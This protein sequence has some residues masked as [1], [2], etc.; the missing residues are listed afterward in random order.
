M[1]VFRQ[2]ANLR[3]LRILV[4]VLPASLLL[5]AVWKQVMI[6]SL[7]AS[8]WNSVPSWSSEDEG[9]LPQAV[10]V[11][12]YAGTSRDTCLQRDTL[13]AVAK[14]LK[15]SAWISETDCCSWPGVSC[16]DGLVTH[17]SITAITDTPH[18][19]GSGTL[20]VQ[21]SSLR[22]L[23][24]LDMNGCNGIS[25]TLPNGLMNLPR[26][27]HLYSFGTRLSGTIGH[28]APKLQE[29]EMSK[30]K[31][32]G[33]LPTSLPTSLQYIFLE[34]NLLS[35]TLPKSFSRLRRLKELELSE[36]AFSGSVPA[37]VSSLH[38]DHL[39]LQQN[40]AL[41]GVPKSE[42]KGSRC[43]GGADKYLRGAIPNRT[44]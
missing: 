23:Q 14:G 18:V 6:V 40:R 2:Q 42:N 37:S 41:Q 31:I 20:P 10:R 15:A 11:H 34:S 24:V 8:T 26:L 21:V 12:Y 7:S 38:L 5:T 3:F 39:D 35:G 33:T 17:L 27:S 36:N 19:L 13:A 25:G 28:V 43:S 29:L 1:A 16:V 44:S 4:V 22:S 30:N 32:S 9:P